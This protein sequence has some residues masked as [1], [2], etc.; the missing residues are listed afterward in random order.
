VSRRFPALVAAGEAAVVV[1]LGDDIRPAIS[2]RV[3]ALLAVLDARP[4]DGSIDLIPSYAALLVVGDPLATSTGRLIEDVRAAVAAISARHERPAHRTV[5][6]PVVYGDDAGPDLADVARQTGLSPDEVVRKHAGAT[7]RVYFLGFIAG[8][9]YLG[10]LPPELAVP[11]LATPRVHTPAGS[12]GLAESQT[13]I[14]P[15]ASPGGWR[16]I[17]RTPVRLFDATRDPPSLLRPGDRVRFVPMADSSDTSDLLSESQDEEGQKS[18]AAPE[19]GSVPWLRVVEPGPLATVQDLGRWGYGRWGV[20]ASG[21]ADADTLR[22]GN[23]VLGNAPGAAAI[24]MTLRGGTFEILAT[25]AIA[26]V[27]TR[28]QA[29]CDRRPLRWG[30]VEIVPA[31]AQIAIGPFE[32]GAR[33]MLCVAGGVAV[34]AVLGSRSTDLRSGFGGIDGHPLRPGDTIACGQP[35]IPLSRL[36]GR[37]LPIDAMRRPPVDGVWRVRMVP[38]AHADPAVLAALSATAFQVDARADRM[39]VRLAGEARIPGG[40][41]ISEGV[42]R[43]AVQVPPD[44]APLILLA[45]HQTTGGYRAPAVVIRADLWRVAQML[46]GDRVQFDQVAPETAREAWRARQ[47]WIDA[48]D[49]HWNEPP[50][51]DLLA[52]GFAEWDEEK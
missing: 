45:D 47:Q 27:G 36:A 4:P 7:Y 32:R 41:A 39:A 6:I 23:A 9:P 29:T 16:I 40:Q 35:P 42:V 1:R 21:A 44:G 11:R 17:G 52:R 19:A 49:A 8:F 28:G 46:P 26:L 10:G 30:A 5:H 51:T 2:D 25:S 14:Y 22:L 31:G 33:A 13:G 24:E 37:A 12:V 50:P 48:L 34:P 18:A 15:V 38:G 43:G 20:S 3:L